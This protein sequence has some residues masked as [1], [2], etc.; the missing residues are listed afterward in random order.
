MFPGLVGATV[1]TYCPSRMV[2]HLKSESTQ[3]NSETTRITLYCIHRTA[4]SRRRWRS[5]RARAA[6][7]RRGRWRRGCSPTTRASHPPSTLKH[8]RPELYEIRCFSFSAIFLL[9][10]NRSFDLHPEQVRTCASSFTSGL[11]SENC[12]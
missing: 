11:Y 2:E 6:P 7:R 8:S 10:T 9:E 5:S 12:W 3:P 4:G 1:A